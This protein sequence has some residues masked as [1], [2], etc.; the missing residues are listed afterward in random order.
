MTYLQFCRLGTDHMWTYMYS[1]DHVHMNQSAS[2]SSLCQMASDM[3]GRFPQ[4]E[5]PF[6]N[7]V[8]LQYLQKKT[9]IERKILLSPAYFML[10]QDM[11]DEYVLYTANFDQLALWRKK[12]MGYWICEYHRK[13]IMISK[14]RKA[15]NDLEQFRSKSNN[16]NSR[17]FIPYTM[18]IGTCGIV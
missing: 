2:V 8:W 10:S 13:S 4:G 1:S 3:M 5:R 17:L 16:N 12:V 14:D 7:F 11:N 9:H 6:S 15:R 18:L